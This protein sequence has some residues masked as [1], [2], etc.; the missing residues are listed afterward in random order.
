MPQTWIGARFVSEDMREKIEELYRCGLALPMGDLDL[1]S[2]RVADYA[3]EVRA[4][5]AA[6]RDQVAQSLT[7]ALIRQELPGI[8]F[9]VYYADQWAPNDNGQW[10]GLLYFGVA[11]VTRAE[12]E[13]H[14]CTARDLA[15]TS[16]EAEDSPY[17][18]P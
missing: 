8:G 4:D 3:W 16:L 6:E 12:A 15:N 10:W 18:L 14:R 13:L 17:R 9:S 1:T 11:H 5:T 2:T 7:D